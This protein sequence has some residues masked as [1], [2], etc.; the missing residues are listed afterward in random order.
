MLDLF[1]LGEIALS[2]PVYF[3][4][5][6][7]NELFSLSSKTIEAVDLGNLGTTLRTLLGCGG[8]L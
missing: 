6:F 5:G 8:C 3:I 1:S 7:F 4:F 2:L